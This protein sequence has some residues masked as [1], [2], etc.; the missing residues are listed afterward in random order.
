MFIFLSCLFFILLSH[1]GFTGKL[2][3]MPVDFR[4]KM[5]YTINSLPVHRTA[6]TEL[7]TPTVFPEVKYASFCINLN[8][9][10]KKSIWK[11]G[12]IPKV[13]RGKIIFMEGWCGYRFLRWPF[14]S[15][16]IKNSSHDSE[17]LYYWMIKRSCQKPAPTSKA[18]V[19]H[20]HFRP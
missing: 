19:A 7:E 13:I 8:H 17:Q 12:L 10:K 18:Q 16:I 4:R 20:P 2:E 11:S 15:S 3:P 9:Y 14:L 1:C 6:N 5:R